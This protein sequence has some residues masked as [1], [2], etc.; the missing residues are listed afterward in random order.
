M[1]RRF[2]AIVGAALHRASQPQRRRA[3]ALHPSADFALG[4]A[5]SSIGHICDP[6]SDPS[7]ACGMLRFEQDIHLTAEAGLPLDTRPRRTFKPAYHSVQVAMLGGARGLTNTK[8]MMKS[9]AFWSCTDHEGFRALFDL[10]DF[11]YCR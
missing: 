11:R 9:H 2:V 3:T 1:G 5:T 4:T 6:G 7:K 10:H 8:F